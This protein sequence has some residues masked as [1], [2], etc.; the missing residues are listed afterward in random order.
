VLGFALAALLLG[1]AEPELPATRIQV[2]VLAGASPTPGGLGVPGAGGTH[3]V[4]DLTP[5]LA[6]QKQ[7]GTHWLAASR[8]T[9]Q[10]LLRRLPQDRPVT[11]HAL[12]V[13][14][15]SACGA[16]VPA[17]FPNGAAAA[18]YVRTAQPRGEGSLAASLD[19]VARTLILEDKTGAQVVAIGDLDAS[20]GGDLCEAVRALDAAGAQL[21]L[22]LL[23]DRSAPACLRGVRGAP[24]PVAGAVPEPAAPSFRVEPWPSVAD[25]VG[26]DGV[27]GR[28]D[29][30]VRGTG[31][32]AVV[33][34]EPESLYVGPLEPRPGETL[35]LRVLDFP[36]LGVREIWLGE[37]RFGERGRVGAQP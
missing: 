17:E 30:L 8:L 14:S 23:G 35:H 31:E 28:Q 2:E 12:G 18:G 21:D 25:A 36:L 20:C 24:A 19:A 11:L 10:R 6:E 13:A 27:A 29:V 16:S 5:S 37:E 7:Q 34:S 33:I 26:A 9:A 3:V 4:V 1:V 22:V 32:I 15:G